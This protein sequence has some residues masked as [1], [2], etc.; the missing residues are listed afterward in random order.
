[1]TTATTVK[2]VK[3]KYPHIEWMDLYDDGVL[4]EVAIVKRA[5]NGDVHFFPVDHLDT[6]DKKRLFGL[7]TSRNA[8]AF[9][10]WELMREATLNNGCN[11]LEYFHQLTKVR[12]P[13]GRIFEPSL[14]KRGAYVIS[15]MSKAAK[16]AQSMVAE[17]VLARKGKKE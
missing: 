8:T 2:T 3:S 12:S 14:G 11:A 10:L 6:I 15:P 13:S 5:S 17:E 9:P 7:V 16:E 4:I 1:M